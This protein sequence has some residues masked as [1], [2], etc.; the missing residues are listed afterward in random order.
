MKEQSEY[1][2]DCGV[3]PDWDD[4]ELHFDLDDDLDDEGELYDDE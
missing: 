4:L 1:V 2:Y 3:D